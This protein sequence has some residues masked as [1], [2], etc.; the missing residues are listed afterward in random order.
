M[1][2]S[3]NESFLMSHRRYR[4][5][6]RAES[7]EETRRRIV[8]ATHLLHMEQPIRATSMTEIA[9]RAGVSVGTVYH[10]F[11]TYDDAIVACGR[12]TAERF[13][14]PTAAIFDG[15]SDPSQRV[16]RL[17]AEVFGYFARFAAFERIRA[18]SSGLPSVEQG[19]AREEENRIALTREALRPLT[20]DARLVDA[21]AALLDAAVHSA[22]KRAGL[23][24]AEAA[25]EVARFILARLSCSAASSD[26]QPC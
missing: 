4:L 21:A 12:F 3:L 18:E 10:H 16:E 23:T 11:P 9:Q 8:E 7:A 6:R 15:V 22:L 19:F 26:D 13:P 25:A 14:F 1:N 2:Y 5:G 20:S 24:T 17:G